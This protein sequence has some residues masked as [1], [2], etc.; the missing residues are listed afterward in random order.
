[1]KNIIRCPYCNTEYLPGE[2]FLPNHFLGKPKDVERDYSGK[3]IYYDGIEQDLTESYICDK[4]SST[5][6]V[7]ASISYNIKEKF[8]A[9]NIYTQKI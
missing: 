1:M 7:V 3:I 2:I 4:C 8:N 9:K 6:E 5:F